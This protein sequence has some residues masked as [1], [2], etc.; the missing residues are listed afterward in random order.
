M[1]NYKT[2]LRRV[3]LII[4]ILLISSNIGMIVYS[5]S[6]EE[7][8]WTMYLSGTGLN[9]EDIQWKDVLIPEIE[10]ITEGRLKID[11]L[12]L[13][14]H[15]Y[16]DRDLLIAVSQREADLINGTYTKWSGIEPRLSIV[17][18]PM[19]VPAN[20]GDL[21]RIYL[22]ILDEVFN[23]ILINKWNSREVLTTWMGAQHFF[24]HD[25]YIENFDSLKGKK[26]RTFNPELADLVRMLNGSP[27]QV[28][29]TEVYT[30]LQLGALDGLITGISNGYN[31]MYFEN[32]KNMQ[33]TFICDC[34]NPVLINNDS[35]NELPE[36][37]QHILQDYFNSKRDWYGMG[38]TLYNGL[39]LIS[40]FSEYGLNV[41]PMSSKLRQ[42]I[43]DRS[44]EG[45][46]KPWIERCGEGG[47]ETFDAI[48]NILRD[49][50]FKVPTY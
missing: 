47:Q 34:T 8:H 27:T 19:L 10:K 42:E 46:W 18:M 38:Q 44:F 50:G 5:H 16:A 12:Y 26:I 7:I 28:D 32:V 25:F 24:F 22:R 31:H 49:E 45:I 9:W 39:N 48:T 29:F 35:W 30:S 4:V 6:E 37:L 43:V 41:R 21:Q 23:E 13:N 20:P 33:A 40:S 17:D 11:L 2:I 3:L 1:M 36:D 15:P 14:E